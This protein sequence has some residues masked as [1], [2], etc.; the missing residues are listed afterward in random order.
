MKLVLS[1]RC[2]VKD[3]NGLPIEGVHAQG[4]G[5]LFHPVSSPPTQ[6]DTH[7]VF[8]F[9]SLFFFKLDCLV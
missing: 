5:S 9:V 8:P 7:R 3:P 2:F 4:G 6:A 1:V